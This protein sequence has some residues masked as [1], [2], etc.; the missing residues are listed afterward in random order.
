MDPPWVETGPH[1]TGTGPGARDVPE[2]GPWGAIA[3]LALALV[4][5]VVF[6]A[7]QTLVAA[8]F[9]WG[10]RRGIDGDVISA[11][12]L[13]SSPACIGVVVLLVELRRGPGPRDYLALRRIRALPLLGWIAAA[14]VTVFALDWLTSFWEPDEVPQFMRDAYDTAGARWLLWVAMVVAAPAFEEVFFRGF[15]FAGLRKS[16]GA[17]GAVVISAVLF[18]VVH[19]QYDAVQRGEVF[20]LGVLLAVARLRSGSV[21]TSFAMHAS[22][23]FV[24]TL[25]A[26]LGG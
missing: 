6:F 20:A 13:A 24:A 21:Y 23:N 7:T 14:I 15:L 22:V 9:A 11:A 12:T 8:L 10:G 4:V 3:T 5:A 19:G 26:A 25:Q 17:A 16:T 1:A 2:R 18:A